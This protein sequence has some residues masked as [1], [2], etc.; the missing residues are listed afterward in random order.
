[1][2]VCMYIYIYSQPW[3]WSIFVIHIS[4]NCCVA[5]VGFTVLTSC[6]VRRRRWRRRS[7]SSGLAKG[8]QSA[9]RCS[10]SPRGARATS[11][12]PT[13][14]WWWSR[15]MYW[16]LHRL[17]QLKGPVHPNILYEY[18]YALSSSVLSGAFSAGRLC[19]GGEALPRPPLAEPGQ[20]H[21]Q[22]VRTAQPG[23]RG[24]RCQGRSD[25]GPR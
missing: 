4:C 19:S 12:S 23:E 3:L 18:A 17:V 22:H 5:A 7:A 24:E 11:V 15:S 21:K 8:S 10:L 13:R 25:R 9:T 1:M 2:Y 20:S 16:K 6:V 14:T